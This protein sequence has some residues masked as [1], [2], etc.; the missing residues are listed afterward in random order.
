MIILKLGGGA[1]LFHIQNVTV[2]IPKR[3]KFQKEQNSARAVRLEK[4]P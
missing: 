1:R 4:K 3:I 2:F